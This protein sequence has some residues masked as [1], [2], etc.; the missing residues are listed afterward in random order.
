[1]SLGVPPPAAFILFTDLFFFFPKETAMLSLL[2]FCFV[3]VFFFK[4]KYFRYKLLYEVACF[5]IEGQEETS[6]VRPC[7]LKA[8]DVFDKHENK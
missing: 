6:T 3:V 5:I 7:L 8:V 4:K 2:N 1:M